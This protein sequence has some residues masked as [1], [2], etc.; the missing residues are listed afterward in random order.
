[1]CDF[2]SKLIKKSNRSKC[3]FSVTIDT[4]NQRMK[5][6]IQE[7]LWDGI[8]MTTTELLIAILVINFH[9]Y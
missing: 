7:Q 2:L 6:E 9:F 1:M 5:G 8:L 4:L 3:Y